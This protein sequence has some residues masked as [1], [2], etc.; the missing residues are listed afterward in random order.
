MAN[1]INCQAISRSYSGKTLFENVSFGIDDGDRIA[2]IG[3]NGAG[4]STL[5]RIVA[6]MEDTDSGT[7]TRRK[8]LSLVYIP[9]VAEFG[10]DQ[11]AFSA[12][13][14]RVRQSGVA[15]SDA[16][17]EIKKALSLTGF[18]DF[19]VPVRTLS[20]GW[21]K[22][23]AIAEALVGS[24][25]LVLFDEPTNH[26]D[27]AGVLWLEQMLRQAPFAWVVISHD[28][29]F[30]DRTVRKTME[31]S[32]AYKN[33]LLIANTGYSEF[34]DK[35]TE[36]LA[37]QAAYAESLANKVRREEEW[38][39]RGPKARTTKSKSRIG[40]AYDMQSELADLKKRL[41]TDSTNIEFTASG[42]KTK[43]L[44][45]CEHLKKQLGGRLLVD[46]LSLV[47]TPGTR[48][49]LLGPNGSGK[50]TLLKMMAGL[51]E[52]DSGTVTHA[53]QLRWIYFDQNRESLDPA[54]TLKRA[55]SDAGDAVVFQGRSIHVMTW[56]KRFGFHADQLNIPVHELSGGEQARVL[57]ARLMLE[58]ADVL[59]L[60]EPTNDLDIPTLEMLG[61]SLLD[62]EGAIVLI[63]HD[64]YLVNQVCDGFVGLSGDGV[65]QIF[66]DYSQW[67]AQLEAGKAKKGKPAA[68][69]AAP[70]REK[71]TAPAQAKRL[72]YMD[73]REYDRLEGDI[74]K[75]EA[76]L[77][78]AHN[79]L[80][81]PSL[82]ADA[83]KLMEATTR[84]ETAQ[85]LVDRLYSRWEE[86][87]AKLR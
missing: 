65:S 53:D 10:A 44:I 57:I 51:I 75:A 30:L 28:R 36:F 19:Y 31:L 42:R 2:I 71:Q 82:I 4:K 86:L 81:D 22:R 61:E 32:P 13:R 26:L 1:L 78:A 20:G 76:E 18:E 25:D 54:W 41:T 70:E 11:T 84:A 39:S 85:A 67:Q 47:L 14:E 64:R 80:E 74:E 6:G 27:L 7:V 21:R 52:P 34:Q 45:A 87:E 77:A 56:A 46:D 63:S 15:L 40:A 37:E 48:L 35:R 66:A 72:S 12:L 29:Y 62:F 16:D 8:D 24:H 68:D 3:A 38:L 33:G 60:D 49:G 9:Q 23:L 50:S 59:L 58:S 83:A 17:G 43:R 5:L 73:Q 69:V 79:S 55:L